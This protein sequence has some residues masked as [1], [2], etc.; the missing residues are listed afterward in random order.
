MPRAVTIGKTVAANR[1]ERTMAAEV[2]GKSRES[3][4]ND[5][6]A[7]R[8]A[9][10]ITGD[11]L[12]DRFSPFALMFPRRD[13][14]HDVPSKQVEILA[15]PTGGPWMKTG[16]AIEYTKKVKP[17]VAFPIHDAMHTE[18]YKRGF[19]PMV[20]SNNLRSENIEF[21]DLAE[22]RRCG[23]DAA[24]AYTGTS[25]TAFVGVYGRQRTW[26]QEQ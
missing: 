6:L 17:R 1:R 19:I 21:R 5:R 13:A 15:L 4:Q 7:A 22:G 8:L 3:A 18:D 9:R 2:A 10:E 12:F 26:Q 11:V 20:L 25:P 16:E 23:W 24:S 14:L